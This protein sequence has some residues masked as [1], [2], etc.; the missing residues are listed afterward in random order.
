M[1]LI[2]RGEMAVIILDAMSGGVLCSLNFAKE[3]ILE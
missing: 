1:K 2:E 3:A